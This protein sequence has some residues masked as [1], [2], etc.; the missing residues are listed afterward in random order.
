[1]QIKPGGNSGETN[2]GVWCLLQAKKLSMKQL[3]LAVTPGEKAVGAA[4]KPPPMA[5][6]ATAAGGCSWK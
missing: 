2:N 6:A 4:A 1:L 5:N 3:L